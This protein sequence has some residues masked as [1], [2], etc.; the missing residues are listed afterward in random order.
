MY[1]TSRGTAQ[2]QTLSPHEEAIAMAMVPHHAVPTNGG[3]EHTV[4]C[5]FCNGI[6]LE[7]SLTKHMK[8]VHGDVF[9]DAGIK[10]RIANTGV[11]LC[12]AKGCG[13]RIEATGN[14]IWDHIF[15]KHLLLKAPP[16][17]NP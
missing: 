15:R 8:G 17:E 14:A 3:F 1:T 4:H 2:V 10:A 16:F 9:S 13:L 6:V 7:R 5:P 12:T 11:Y